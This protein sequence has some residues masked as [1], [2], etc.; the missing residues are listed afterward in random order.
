MR[1]NKKL[2]FQKIIFHRFVPNCGNVW[3]PNII[4]PTIRLANPASRSWCQ[5]NGLQ[6]NT[7]MKKPHVV[8]WISVGPHLTTILAAGCILFILWIKP[9]GQNL[10]AGRIWPADRTLDMTGINC[11]PGVSKVF[12]RWAARGETN[13][14]GAA[15]DYNIGRRPYSI[16]FM[17]QATQAG[18]KLIAGRI[19]PTGR[20][21]EMPALSEKRDTM[22][23]FKRLASLFNIKCLQEL[24]HP[25]TENLSTLCKKSYLFLLN[26][27]S[28][29]KAASAAVI[30]ASCFRIRCIEPHHQNGRWCSGVCKK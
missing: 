5:W 6:K 11:R 19:W 18:Q 2:Q 17:N 3:S 30:H 10:I 21:L 14:Y 7:K 26:P 4:I 24:P 1:L 23:F 12:A 16:H 22:A 27:P 15:F 25:L 9:R 8:R 28:A 29:N 20:T 13:I